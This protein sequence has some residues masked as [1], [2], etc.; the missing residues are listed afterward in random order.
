MRQ[1]NKYENHLKIKQ[2]QDKLNRQEN[3]TKLTE[4]SRFHVI[5]DVIYIIFSNYKGKMGNKFETGAKNHRDW[6]ANKESPKSPI[7]TIDDYR[8]YRKILQN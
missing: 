8:T 3:K 5:F 6:I 7:K 4:T 2:I 1:T